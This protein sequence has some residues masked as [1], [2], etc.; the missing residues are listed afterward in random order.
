M[1]WDELELLKRDPKKGRVGIDL[2]TAVP[3]VK[4]A[5]IF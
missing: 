5:R 1:F 2:K 3:R 4:G